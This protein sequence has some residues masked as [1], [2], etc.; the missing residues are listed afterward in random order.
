MTS[1][2]KQHAN[3]ISARIGQR[4]SD[5]T[6]SSSEKSMRHLKENASTVAGARVGRNSASVRKILQQL[7]RFPDYVA[8]ASSMDVRDETNSA[9]VVFV[10]R[11]IQSLRCRLTVHGGQSAAGVTAASSLSPVRIR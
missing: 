10:G 8:G 3:A 9:R 7:E 2:E 6:A 1:R 5:V 4:D 11:I